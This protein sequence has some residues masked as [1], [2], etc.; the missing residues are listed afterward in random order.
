MATLVRIYAAHVTEST[1]FEN[2][3]KKVLP[4]FVEEIKVNEAGMKRAN[5]YGQYQYFIDGEINGEYFSFKLHTTDSMQWDW[6]QS[7][8]TNR[9]FENWKKRKIIFL[10]EKYFETI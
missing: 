10:L 6:Y 1:N 9:L 4:S 3:I 7:C 2:R 8:E 5:G